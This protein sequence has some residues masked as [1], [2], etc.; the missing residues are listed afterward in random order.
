MEL[1]SQRQNSSLFVSNLLIKG[2]MT[3]PALK[4]STSVTFLALYFS[5]YSVFKSE[6]SKSKFKSIL[7]LFLKEQRQK[8]FTK[9]KDVRA[10]C[11]LMAR[12]TYTE[13]E[14]WQE[15]WKKGVQHIHNIRGARY[16]TLSWVNS[17]VCAMY[18]KHRL[19]GIINN[20]RLSSEDTIPI[21]LWNSPAQM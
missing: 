13:P 1:R 4:Y 3:L 8:Y 19:F 17:T 18:N 10:E 2:Q 15:A 16:Y 5:H 12:V 11:E 14:H 21:Y 9:H 7:L 6:F 20:T